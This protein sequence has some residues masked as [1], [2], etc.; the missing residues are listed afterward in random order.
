MNTFTKHEILLKPCMKSD[1]LVWYG[2]A[3][4]GMLFERLRSVD[5]LLAL[6]VHGRETKPF[7]LRYTLKGGSVLLTLGLWDSALRQA[8]LC[9]LWP[10]IEV[11]ISGKTYTLETVFLKSKFDPM[12]ASPI[13]LSRQF[14]L[15][16]RSPTCFRSSGRTLLFPDWKRVLASLY[17]DWKTAGGAMPDDNEI[18]SLTAGIYPAHYTLETKEIH[19]GAFTLTGFTGFCVY[20][21]APDLST[22]IRNKLAAVIQISDYAG[23]GYKTTMGMGAVDVRLENRKNRSNF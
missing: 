9:A 7:S 12:D 21:T 3:L 4:N 20:K 1:N 8:L 15:S 10:G 23:V 17:R 6:S 16:F 13:E 14:T 18:A 19:F 11:S 22:D 5:E 2:Q